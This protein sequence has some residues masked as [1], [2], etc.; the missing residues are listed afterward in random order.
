MDILV[1]F[2]LWL[3][4]IMKILAFKYKF[5]CKYIFS[6][7]LLI[8]I[9]RSGMTGLNDN[10]IFNILRN[11]CFPKRLH[12]FTFPPLMYTSSSSFITLPTLITV[13]FFTLVTLVGMTQCLT[14]LICLMISDI[15]H[16]LMCLFTICISSL[17]K[18]QFKCFAHSSVG[19]FFFLIF[20]L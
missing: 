17:Q 14:A 2:N 5:L 15:D 19:C 9:P 12:H 18:C 7:L 16:L 8:Y 10:S 20:G 11:C 1:P 13:Y 4:W 3:L 6:Y